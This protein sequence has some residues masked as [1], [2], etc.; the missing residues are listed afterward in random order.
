MN[1]KEKQTSVSQNGVFMAKGS[2]QGKCT[3]LIRK[4]AIGEPPHSWKEELFV[5]CLRIDGLPSKK[6]IDGLRVVLVEVRNPLNIGAAARALSNFGGSHLR[7]VN[8]YEVA[9][10]EAQSAVGAADL[11]KKAKEFQTVAEAVSD[12]ALVVGTTAGQKRELQHTLHP[13]ARG[14]GLIRSQMRLGRV[15]L[16]FGSERTGLSNADFTHCHWLMHIPT[17][18][19]HLSMNLGQAVAVCLYE[20][21]RDAR[22]KSAGVKEPKASAGTVERLGEALRQ[23][24]VDSGYTKPRAESAAEE[25]TRRMLKRLSI[26]QADAEV[27]LGMLRQIAWKIKS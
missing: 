11:L 18:E 24:L 9:F 25:R 17:S 6:E 27:L 19:K 2:S 8:P 3:Q 14:A 5:A 21:T 26:T 16:L 15:A 1:M 4:H 20:I 13:L 7:V 22:T 23:V 12:C 10:R